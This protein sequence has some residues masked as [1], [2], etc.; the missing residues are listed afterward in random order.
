MPSRDI[1]EEALDA[2]YDALQVDPE[3][4]VREDRAFSWWGHRLRQR[5]WVDPP[6]ES[7]GEVVVHLHAETD[8][9]EG[10]EFGNESLL[11][12]SALN[13][14][15]DLSALTLEAPSGRLSLQSN[16]YL[17]AGNRW[18]VQEVKA[19]VALQAAHAHELAEVL[20]SSLGGRVAESAHPDTGL[21]GEPDN[22]LDVGT[23]FR[24]QGSMPTP[25]VKGDFSEAAREAR[26]F[27]VL[28]TYDDSSLTGEIAYRGRRPVT[29]DHEIADS[30]ERRALA[31]GYM[32]VARQKLEG[33]PAVHSIVWLAATGTAGAGADTA[34]LQI[35]S[36]EEH[37]ALGTGLVSI[38]WLPER[39]GD[40]ESARLANQLNL[41]EAT[42][43]TEAHL[44]G[45]WSARDGHLA[46]VS[47]LP[48]MLLARADASARRARLINLIVW[49]SIRARWAATE[50]TT[51][52]H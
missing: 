37:P 41:R 28:A 39:Y 31:E 4:G 45:S 38:L 15:A 48:N 17:H 46:F 47:F 23:A 33:V 19:A 34:L 11:K 25:F 1:G 24:Q 30:Q 7:R 8:L 10:V 36:R 5:V 22:M 20:P 40:E 13:E 50:L 18:M 44:Q 14:L 3:W 21:R 2:V 42:E 51:K 12:V 52:R 6:R 32:Q 9:L 26:Q 43:W 49:A 27:L 35:R 16:A 29:L